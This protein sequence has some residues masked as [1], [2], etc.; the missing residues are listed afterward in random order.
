MKIITK[1]FLALCLVSLGATL[2][3]NA[4]IRSDATIRVN[5][6]YSFVVNN[7]TL[8]AGTYVITAADPYASDL[9]VLQI[10]SANAKTAVL[11]ETESVAVPGL[12]KR[13]E[14]VFDKIG[15]TYFLS[16]VFLKGDG[17]GNQLLKS[18]MQQRLQENGSIAE[19]H[20]IP[21]SPTLAKSSKRA[22]R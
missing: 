3:A 1:L 11:F 10:R 6:P 12:A 15:D 8:P 20:S 16:K 13:T 9:T 5:I 14:L 22:G 4:Q 17:G 21:A 19:S 18:K 2:T 7:T